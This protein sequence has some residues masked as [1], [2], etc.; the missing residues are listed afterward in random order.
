M[1]IRLAAVISFALLSGSDAARADDVYLKNGR[2]F[3][4][5][6]AEVT[7][8]QVR[9]R[10]PGGLLS[11]PLSQVERVEKADSSFAEYLRRKEALRRAP[12]A[13][14]GD[15]LDLARWARSRGLSQGARESA[16]LAAQLD[17]HLS[18][19][20]PLMRGLGYVLD[21]ELDRW[22]PYADSMRRRGFVQSNGQWISR[23]EYAQ[24][25]RR[26]EEDLA[27]LRAARAEVEARAAQVAQARR[28]AELEAREER[29]RERRLYAAPENYGIPLYGFP[30]Y[31]VAPPPAPPCCDG[32]G[33]P[34]GGH[35]QPPKP[36]ERPRIDN[37]SS[38]YTRM[39]GSLIPG[40]LGPYAPMSGGH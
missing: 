31:W 40:R 4:G 24:R 23:E 3:E 18:G 6:I 20:E 27:R 38:T 12:E 33:H 28:L 35:H 8:S 32:P 37:G 9:I 39:P 10:M 19:L 14:A 2:S 29:E 16:L 21:K 11:L 7:D 25:Q 26:Q 17:P 34:G 36:P 22:I 1:R 13:P 30:G 15:W 5:V